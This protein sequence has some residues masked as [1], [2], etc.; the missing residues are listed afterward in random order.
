MSTSKASMQVS[1]DFYF[2]QSLNIFGGVLSLADILFWA[3]KPYTKVEI[4]LFWIK[5]RLCFDIRFGG[6]GLRKKVSVL[7]LDNLVSEKSICFGQFG[8][9]KKYLFRK[10]WSQKKNRFRFRKIL[11][12][13]RS[14]SFGKFG[15][16]KKISVSVSVKILVSS[17]SAP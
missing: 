4:E 14:L 10:I 2:N 17:F 1:R 3:M 6:F 12:R 7:V 9:Q 16:G 5:G 11:W 8:L 15:I 13:K